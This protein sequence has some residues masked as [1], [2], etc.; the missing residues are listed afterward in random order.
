[1]QPR[2]GL[3]PGPSITG[4]GSITL[5]GA[6]HQTDAVAQIDE[7]DAQTA[8]N[9]LVALPSS[10][11]LTGHD[12]GTVG[13]LAPGVYTFSS[14]AQLTGTLTLDFMSNP[15][16]PFVFQIGSGLTTA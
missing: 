16:T 10:M 3:H 9:A 1:M 15:N 5:N 7:T 6:V 12:L 8:F 4:L 2:L 14:S 11:N 13:V